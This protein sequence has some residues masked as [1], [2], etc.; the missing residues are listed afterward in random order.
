MV[1]IAGA[2]EVHGVFSKTGRKRGR[3]AGEASAGFVATM[4]A[5][6]ARV[7]LGL[8]LRITSNRSTRKRANSMMADFGFL[9]TT[10]I[11]T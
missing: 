3:D 5:D 10:T 1:I 4:R 8:P 2:V 6:G 7:S 11:I 9:G